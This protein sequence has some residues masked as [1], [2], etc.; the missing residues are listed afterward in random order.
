MTA[1]FLLRNLVTEPGKKGEVPIPAKNREGY[2]GRV[3][4]Y[5]TTIKTYSNMKTYDGSLNK[6]SQKQ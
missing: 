2:P 5:I 4:W 6:P 1:P 3:P